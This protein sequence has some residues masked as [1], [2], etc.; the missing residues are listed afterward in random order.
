MRRIFLSPCR[1]GLSFKKRKDPMDAWFMHLIQ[2]AGF[3]LLGLFALLVVFLIISELK[4]KSRGR[5]SARRR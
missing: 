5:R 3:G 1:N 4:N 2:F